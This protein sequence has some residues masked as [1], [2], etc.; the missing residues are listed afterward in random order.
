MKDGT[1]K[2]PFPAL[3]SADSCSRGGES[4]DLEVCASTPESIKVIAA[5]S[6]KSFK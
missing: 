2:R 6:P 4:G 5:S 3:R 1:T